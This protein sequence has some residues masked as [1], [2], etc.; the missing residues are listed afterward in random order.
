MPRIDDD[1]K[2]LKKE[3]P[4][5]NEIEEKKN[6]EEIVYSAAPKNDM[7]LL[8]GLVLLSVVSIAWSGILMI[9]K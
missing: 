5:P 4:P 7:P 6:S 2:E 8:Y 9:K 1:I 3:A